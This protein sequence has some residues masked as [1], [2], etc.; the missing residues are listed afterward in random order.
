MKGKRFFLIVFSILF[1]VSSFAQKAPKYV[2]YFIGDGMGI[3]MVQ[4]T[5]MYRASVKGELGVDPLVFS[6][7]PV[8]SFGTT[9]SANSD[10]T[11]SAASGTA[12]AT[13]VKTCNSRLGIGPDG[14][15]LESI[16]EKARDRGRK[17][18]IVTTD[19]VNHATPG[20]FY[21]HQMD[22]NMFYEISND[23]IASGFD[24]FAGSHIEK[25]GRLY[26]GTKVRDIREVMSENGY[27][28][29]YGEDEFEANRK[30]SEHMVMLP[31]PKKGL[32]YQIDRKE[33]DTTAMTL[34]CLTKSAIKFLDGKKGFFLMVEGGN[35]DGAE[36]GH[37]GAT[38]IW[39]VLG[40]NDAVAEALSFYNKHKD[41]TLIVVTADHETGG[42][43]LDP[44][45]P[46][47]LALLQYQK[48]SQEEI[49][50]L[51][52]KKVKA[53]GD[54]ILTWEEAKDF[55]SEYTGL[56]TH[57]PVS[58]D[59]EKYLHDTYEFTVAKKELGHQI[60][61]Y[62]D[63][64][65]LVARAVLVLNENAHVHWTTSHSAGM[66][67]VYAIGVGAEKFAGKMDNAIIPKLISQIAN[68]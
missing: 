30:S 50:G 32:W 5:E 13:G 10:V 40:F 52:D 42:V 29:V 21:A 14:S 8:A 24:F 39:E 66:V 48:R 6:N 59:Q 36:H 63:N 31:A 3:N 26:D 9:Y 17:V 61:L 2:F 20:A 22:R 58:W 44:E 55:L 46:G 51:L 57:V 1:S 11:D 27:K 60:D 41:E 16:A 62:A 47:D 49:S 18:G 68:Y 12:L 15:R 33:R 56:W 45:K 23:L 37:D 25:R 19:G 7:F 67:P 64:A 65:L 38:A 34:A 43:A 53:A 54:H 35:I 4:M 28:I